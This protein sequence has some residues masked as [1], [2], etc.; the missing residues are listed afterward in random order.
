MLI[1]LL[2]RLF[3]RRPPHVRPATFGLASS[4]TTHKR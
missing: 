4:I 3:H 2:R 1:A